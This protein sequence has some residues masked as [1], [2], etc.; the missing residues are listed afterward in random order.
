MATALGEALPLPD[1]I[2]R[3]AIKLFVGR[4]QRRL[5]GNAAVA[6][7]RFAAEMSGY[8]IATNVAVA[9]TQHY[10][11]PPEFF[12][13]V[14]GPQ[15]KYSCCLYDGGAVSL[16]AAEERALETTAAHAALSDGQ[17]ILELGCGWGSFSLWMA[18]RYPAARITAVSNSHSQRHFIAG[19]AKSQRLSNLDVVTADMNDFI[20]Q[21]RFDR[22]VSIEMFEHMS[23][24]R[25]LLQRMRDSLA[26]E[27]RMFL[28]IF[29]NAHAPYRFAVDDKNDWIAQHFFTGGIMPSR[30]LLRQ[31][32]DC[33]T[34]ETEWWWNG[35]HYRRTAEDWLRNYDRNAAAIDAIFK[36][37][38][39]RDAR[40]WRR[41]WR[42][43]FL[44]TAGLFGHSGGE[45]WGISHYR[46]APAAP[47]L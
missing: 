37:V 16:A 25:P 4:T 21:G 43:F 24:W 45:E 22:I 7:D 2:T 18:R 10:E 40:L 15:R 19:E 12:T 28:H 29:S 39:G 6:D 23:N 31:F 34:I 38:Y 35:G 36:R 44:A 41:R 1:A 8:P 5:C 47:V 42:T 27:G 33:F 3:T 17:R 26:P 13:L 9:N 32:A 20:P 14:L 11:M 30:R 46:L